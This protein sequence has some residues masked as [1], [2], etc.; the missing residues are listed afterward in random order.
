MRDFL[1]EL[2]TG[3][4]DKAMNKEERGKIGVTTRRWWQERKEKI[5]KHRLASLREMIG[6]RLS[7]SKHSH[8][9]YNR[10]H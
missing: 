6:S 1:P 9:V 3:G 8:L 4:W 2:R 5:T 7:H 10:Q